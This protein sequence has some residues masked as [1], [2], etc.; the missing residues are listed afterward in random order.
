MVCQFGDMSI[1]KMKV[2]DFQGEVTEDIITFDS[3]WDMFKHKYLTKKAKEIPPSLHNCGRDAVPSPEVPRIILEKRLKAATS[4]EERDEISAQ[5]K[6]LIDQRR[7]LEQQT[8]SIIDHVTQD[9]AMTQKILQS[10][11][12]L[13]QF[14]CHRGVVEA[15]HD[16]C[17]NLGCNGF[18]LRQIN[19]FA[20]M[21]ELGFEQKDILTGINKVC[22]S[23]ERICGI[24]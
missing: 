8:K 17:F 2:A 10:A 22:S 19:H 12:E 21:C 13:T 18:A 1:S 11:L 20:T 14:D 6:N 23:N 7:F 16:K 4:D 3:K 24:H 9:E 5:L 15:F